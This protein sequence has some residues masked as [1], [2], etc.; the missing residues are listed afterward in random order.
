MF[1]LWRGIQEL[2]ELGVRGNLIEGDSKV[3]VEWVLGF[4]FP[5]IFLDKVEKIWKVMSTFGFKI[6]WV[7]RSA[8]LSANEMALSGCGCP[9]K[10]SPSFRLLGRSLYVSFGGLI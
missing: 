8:N 2:E 7:P 5:W 9:W 6:V 3:V 1:A 10:L 4:E